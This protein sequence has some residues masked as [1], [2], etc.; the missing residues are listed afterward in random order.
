VTAGTLVTLTASAT[1]AD[2]PANTLTYSLAT[3]PTGATIQP[4]T[5]AFSWTPSSGQTGVHTVTVRVTDNGAPAASATTSF[6]ITV[7]G[8]NLADLVM[9][10]LSTT[11][12]VVRPGTSLSTSSSVRN[13]GTAASG[14]SSV[15][16]FSLSGDANYGGADDVTLTPT[17]TISSL[18][19]NGTSTATLT[20][21]V[22]VS[23]PV[24]TYYLCATADGNSTINES[25]ESN[26][27]R[28]T[29]QTI[30]VDLPGVDVIGRRLPS[31]GQQNHR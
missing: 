11:A 24:G 2:V 16:I 29:T 13:S 1:D 25:N 7:N 28:C 22:P 6:T 3:A 10:A 9:T 15:V 20:L 26:N 17:R 5:G 31:V 4:A 21:T 14:S 8:G 27:T 30:Q 19:V 12:T 23:A 18:S